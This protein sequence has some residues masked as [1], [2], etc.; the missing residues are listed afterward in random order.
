MPTFIS[1]RTTVIGFV[2]ASYSPRESVVIGQHAGRDGLIT[3]K[4]SHIIWLPRIPWLRWRYYNV[5][6]M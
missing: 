1:S 4:N 2:L 6:I 3:I 5:I